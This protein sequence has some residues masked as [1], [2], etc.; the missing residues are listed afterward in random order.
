MKQYQIDEFRLEDYQ[1][2]KHYFDNNLESSM[3]SGVYNLTLDT[4]LLNN[5]QKLH[6]DCQPFY[7][8]ISLT[9][10]YL[11]VELLIRSKN[12][13]KCNC[14]QYAN[15]NQREWLIDYIDN[16]LTTLKINV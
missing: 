2:I 10:N 5:T 16:I 13:M 9:E 12:K 8:S 3:I 6:K 1:K 4:Y 7:F 11:S 14:I 15:K